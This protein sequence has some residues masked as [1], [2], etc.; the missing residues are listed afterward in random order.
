[1]LRGVV[2]VTPERMTNQR[3]RREPAVRRRAR[4]A[5]LSPEDGGLVSMGGRE[6][7]RWKREGLTSRHGGVWWVVV[8]EGVVCSEVVGWVEVG[9]VRRPWVPSR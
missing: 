4:G 9:E 8:V 7:G 3:R 2:W 5:R 6:R 1:M